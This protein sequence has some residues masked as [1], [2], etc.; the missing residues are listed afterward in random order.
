MRPTARDATFA[1]L[2]ALTFPVC[3]HLTLFA[4][5]RHVLDPNYRKDVELAAQ[6]DGELKGRVLSRFSGWRVDADV[7][8]REDRGR[9]DREL[10]ATSR[11]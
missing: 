2:G 3:L 6:D 11:P 9:S 7:S 1:G 5:G 4:L 8:R 10:R